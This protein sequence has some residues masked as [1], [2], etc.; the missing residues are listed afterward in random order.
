MSALTRRNGASPRSAR[1]LAIPPAVSSGSPPRGA[2]EG[3]PRAPAAPQA[4]DDA[5]GEMRDVDHRLAVARRGEALQVPGDERLAAHFHHRLRHAVRERAQSLAFARCK[6]HYPHF[7]SSNNRIN[8]AR[9]EY[10]L[11]TSRA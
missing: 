8:G 2:A 7:S 6:N 1:A 5:P 9:A 11:A 10:L 3:T 4:L